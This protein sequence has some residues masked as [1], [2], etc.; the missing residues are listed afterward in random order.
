MP[1]FVD[2]I[3]QTFGR[4]T[5]ILR[6]PSRTL[7]GKNRSYWVCRCICGNEV[8]VLGESLV[9]GNTRSCACQRAD[10]G[11]LHTHR[12]SKTKTYSAWAAA[13]ARCSNPK[14]QVYRLYGARGITMCQAWQESFETFLH[15]MGEAPGGLELDRIDNNGH[16]EPGNC[17]WTT[18]RE[19]VRN[20]RRMRHLR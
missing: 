14:H 12:M 10:T 4:L 2:R 6:A 19:Q 8:E 16:Y 18:R 5:V 15:D 20:S 13:K 9:S 3:G 7:S 17:R 11:G 1:A